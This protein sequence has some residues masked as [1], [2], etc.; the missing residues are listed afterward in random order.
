MFDTVTIATPQCPLIRCSFHLF[1]SFSTY[2][3]PGTTCFWR[4]VFS[5][6]SLLHWQSSE[7]HEGSESTIV[8]PS[9]W[10]AGC[11]SGSCLPL[12]WWNSRHVVPHGGALQVRMQISCRVC[13]LRLYIPKGGTSQLLLFFW[14]T[15]TVC[16]TALTYHYET[17]C[18]PT[19]LAWFAHQLPV[20]WQKLSVMATF[21]IE[22]AA[23]PLFFSPLRR[24]RLGAFYMQ[25]NRNTFLLFFFFLKNY[26]LSLC[27]F[28]CRCSFKCS[29]FWLATTIS[30][31]YWLWP[32]ACRFWMTSMYTSGYARR[33]RSLT[34]VW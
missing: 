9:G 6:S 7:G 34:M 31:T 3:C 27:F 18:I 26:W 12:V 10:P 30:S 17:Q 14:L 21:V 2:C 25:V 33:K 4:R 1:N 8:W 24:L 32:S 11:S 20:W 15:F 29:S 23:P 22:I 16:L 13:V 19:W 28:L 5:V